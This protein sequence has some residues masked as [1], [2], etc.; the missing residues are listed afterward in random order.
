[1]NSYASANYCYCFQLWKVVWSDVRS[2]ASFGNAHEQ[3]RQ[4]LAGPNADAALVLRS[5]VRPFDGS[6]Q[7]DGQGLQLQ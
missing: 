6:S 3:T 1:M 2:R 7:A 5:L 4:I